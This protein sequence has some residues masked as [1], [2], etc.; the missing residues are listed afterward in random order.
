MAKSTTA[1]CLQ[2]EHWLGNIIPY[3]VQQAGTP[4]KDIHHISDLISHNGICRL[5]R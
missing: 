1:S 2:R 4:V 5:R 3:E